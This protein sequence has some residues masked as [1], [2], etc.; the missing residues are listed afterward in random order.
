[1]RSELEDKA[2]KMAVAYC[3]AALCF[4]CLPCGQAL[5]AEEPVLV[6]GAR[7]DG[8]LDEDPQ[9]GYNRIANAIFPASEAMIRFQRMP[10]VR[11]VDTFVRTDRVCLLPTSPDVLALL[12]GIQ[13]D[14]LIGGDPIDLVSSHLFFRTAGDID[15]KILGRA[16]KRLAKQSGLKLEDLFGDRLKAQVLQVPEMVI[17]LRMLQA[18]RVDAIYAWYPDVMIISER[19]GL[20]I[21]AFDM[22]AS[23]IVLKTTLTCKKYEGVDQ[24]LSLFNSRLASLKKSGQLSEM[25]G[26]YARVAVE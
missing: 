13:R 26:K 9:S 7:L 24:T 15:L 3:A 17:A 21:P 11:A 16:D 14:E 19:F 2:W 12:G 5:A 22:N 18:K 23:D 1:M 20:E 4:F 25:L 10:M 8:R 6:V